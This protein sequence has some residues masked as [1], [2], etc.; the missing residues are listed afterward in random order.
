MPTFPALNDSTLAHNFSNSLFGLIGS[1]LPRTTDRSFV[2]A[3]AVANVV[4]TAAENC[5]TGTKIATTLNN[6]TFDIP[7][8]SSILEAY[9]YKKKGVY[10]TD[11]PPNPPEIL[12]F[13][14]SS[15]V[16]QYNLTSHRG[17]KTLTLKYNQTVQIV[18]QDV[19]VYLLDYHPFHLHG[20]SFHVV[21]SGFGN[22]NATTD[23]KNFNLVDPPMRNTVGL[24]DG[25]W[26]AIRFLANNPGEFSHPSGLVEQMMLP[27]SANPLVREIGVSKREEGI[28]D[29]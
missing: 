8:N 18:L 24:L 20:H 1:N 14:S 21:G 16:A 23:P 22:F 6:V 11:F 12:N 4:C 15:T 7:T 3:A 25:G 26:V 10:T 19:D 17:A 28:V 29:V 9:Y 27:K 5:T 13:T 2:F